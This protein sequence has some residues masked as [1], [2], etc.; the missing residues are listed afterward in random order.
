MKISDLKAGTGNV[1]ITATIVQKE[2]PR[3]VVNKFGK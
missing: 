3:E 1:N 2:E